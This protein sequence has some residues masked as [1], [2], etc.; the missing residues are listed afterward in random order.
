MPTANTYI[1]PS[2]GWVQI[3]NAP[4]F[5]RVT[6][7]PATHPFYLYAGSSAPSLLAT[8]GSG[9]VTF[10]TAVPTAGNTVTVGSETYTF[11]ASATLPFEVTIGADFHASATNFTA[12]VNAQ[13]TLVN[14]VDVAD[15]VTLT[16]KA[17]GTQ[18]NYT[19]AK[20]GANIAVS[21]AAFTG[22]ANV[23]LGILVIHHPFKV[24]V[25]MTEKLYAR[26]VDSV[27]NSSQLDGKVRMDVFT[28]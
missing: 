13:S 1:G 7:F 18:G 16:S 17:V 3:A 27:P 5:V 28:V 14:A 8:A 2:D 20:V 10:S 4:A 15:V 26:V 19:L 23:A 21:G 6:S 25:T 22:G 12:I 24:N 11:R 9:T